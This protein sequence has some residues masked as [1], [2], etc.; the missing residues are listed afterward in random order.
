V[1]FQLDRDDARTLAPRFLPQLTTDDLMGIR[2]YEAVLRLCV[3]GQTRPAV[4]GHTLPLDEPTQ[5]AHAL[6]MES[7]LRFGAVR[8]DVEAALQARTTVGSLPGRIGR[9]HGEPA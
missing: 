4:T 2:A 5:D 7:R 1:T 8:A 9:K 3:D 6:A